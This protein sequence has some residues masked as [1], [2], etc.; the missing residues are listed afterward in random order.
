VQRD[1]RRFGDQWLGERRSAVLLVPSVVLQGRELNVLIN[2][3]HSDFVRIKTTSP[4]TVIWD[5]RLF[6]H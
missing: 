5:P 3:D 2:P 1:S 4:E 6:S